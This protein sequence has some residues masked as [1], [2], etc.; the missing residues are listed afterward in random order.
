MSGGFGKRKTGRKHL[1]DSRLGAGG[2][3][4]LVRGGL[5][6]GARRRPYPPPPS[7][8]FESLRDPI[9]IIPIP[10]SG[11]SGLLRRSTALRKALPSACLAHF[12]QRY[13]HGALRT[14]LPPSAGNSPLSAG[15][16]GLF[17]PERASYPL[18]GRDYFVSISPLSVR[19]FYPTYFL[20]T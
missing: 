17:S 5:S 11:L 3:P 1:A 19:T 20:P 16:D 2:L 10:F 14:T 4:A 8:L 6:Q 13:A 12:C 7:T 9:S 15:D 18:H